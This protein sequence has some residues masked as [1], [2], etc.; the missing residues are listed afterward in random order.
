MEQL[1]NDIVSLQRRFRD[2]LDDANHPAARQLERDIQRLEDDAQVRKNPRTIE[3]Q[4]KRI[5]A[6]LSNA[7]GSGFM[8]DGH[9][10]A[11]KDQLENLR[12]QLQRLM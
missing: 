1:H 7:D 11:L 3:D 2:W 8:D 6:Q 4:V 9:I 12:K 10:D 5:I